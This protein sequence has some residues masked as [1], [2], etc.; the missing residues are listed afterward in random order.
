[1][2]TTSAD[3]LGRAQAALA[4]I[5]REFDARFVYFDVQLALRRNALHVTGL[6]HY[7]QLREAVLFKLGEE[8]PNVEVEASGLKVLATDLPVKFALVVSPSSMG[9]K[10]PSA[11]PKDATTE[12]L[13]GQVV[14]TFVKRQGWVLTQATDGYMGWVKAADLKAVSVDFY[15]QWL[16]GKRW[17][18]LKPWKDGRKGEYRV[19]SEFSMDLRGRLHIPSRG[20]VNM[21]QFPSGELVDPTIHPLR[22]RALE[23]ARSYSGSPYLWGGRTD[24]GV[25]CSGFMQLIYA[26]LGIALPRDANQQ[27][28]TGALVGHL[29]DCSDLMP[30]DLIFFMSMKTGKVFHVGLSAGGAA[31]IHSESKN[32]VNEAKLDTGATATGH[33]YSAQYCFA[34]RILI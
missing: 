29:A 34:R 31:F 25:D 11:P 32:G 12:L 33:A 16:Q 23:I 24:R 6:V 13:A 7:P 30:G 15:R 4:P 19:G 3:L 8:L 14:R 2:T 28:N 18:L 9:L 22:L 21:A 1:M 27:A 26:R 20:Y 10:T 17:R 5:Y